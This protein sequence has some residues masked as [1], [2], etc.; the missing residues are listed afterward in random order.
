MRLPIAP[1]WVRFPGLPIHLIHRDALY[2]I[3]SE[4]GKPLQVDRQT[5]EH[6]RLTYAQVYIEMDLLQE[7]ITD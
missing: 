2:T 1:A 6:S 7:S 3:A 5:A 4:F